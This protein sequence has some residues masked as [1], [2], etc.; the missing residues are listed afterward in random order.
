MLIAA[1]GVFLFAMS[2][3]NAY[4]LW[5][6]YHG[7]MPAAMILLRASILLLLSVFTVLAG[8]D[9][10]ERKIYLKLKDYFSAMK[11]KTIDYQ[12]TDDGIHL[13]IGD[14]DLFYQWSRIEYIKF[15]RKFFYF[16]SGG[17]HSI[18]DKKSLNGDDTASFERLMKQNHIPYMEL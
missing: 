3:I 13:M 15:D 17:R 16:T 11:V 4:G 10:P 2:M 18:I 8:I 14:A 7:T 5:M 1:F 12:I 9:G 6:K